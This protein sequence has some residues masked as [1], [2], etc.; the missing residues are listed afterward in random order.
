MVKY[1]HNITTGIVQQD[2]SPANHAAVVVAWDACAQP[3]HTCVTIAE[4]L[5]HICKEL[6]LSCRVAPPPPA[7][8][9]S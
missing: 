4:T 2:N 5:E 8:P 3:L 9:G 7:L 1:T 6:V